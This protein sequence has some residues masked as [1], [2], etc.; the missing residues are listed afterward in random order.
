MPEDPID[1]IVPVPHTPLSEEA[2]ATLQQDLDAED[3]VGSSKTHSDNE[4]YLKLQEAHNKLHELHNWRVRHRAALEDLAALNLLNEKMTISLD[5]EENT[6]PEA[7]DTNFE[8]FKNRYGETDGK[9]CIEALVAGSDFDEQVRQELGRRGELDENDH[10][11]RVNYEDNDEP[12]IQRV[13]I[14][15]PALLWLLHKSLGDDSPMLEWRGQNRTTFYRPFTWFVYAREKMKEELKNLEAHWSS[16]S[17]C[18]TV[19]TKRE[20]MEETAARLQH[21]L[22]VD[23]VSESATVSMEPGPASGITNEGTITKPKSLARRIDTSLLQKALLENYH[24]LL[25]LRCYT[26]F[27]EKR[28][29]P[30]TRRYEDH[31]K[32]EAQTIRYQ[33]LWLLFPL[34]SLLLPGAICDQVVGFP[35]QKRCYWTQPEYLACRSRKA[36]DSYED[37]R[38]YFHVFEHNGEE[39][40]RTGR[41]VT[42]IFLKVLRKK[43]LGEN[44]KK[45]KDAIDSRHMGYRG[46][47]RPWPPPTTSGPKGP[48]G[49]DRPSTTQ[50]AESAVA[51]VR[52]QTYIE[53]DI[54]V[55]VKEAIRV[56]AEAIPFFT[57]NYAG[58]A[59]LFIRTLPQAKD[60]KNHTLTPDDLLLL[61]DRIYA[62]ALRERKFFK[63]DVRY[64]CQLQT[65]VDAFDSLKIDQ[66][67]IRIVQA[68]VASHF[69]R[70]GMEDRPE[71]MNM[72]DQDLIR[73]KGRGL[74]ILLHGAPGV[75]KTATAEAVALW[76]KRPLFVITC[77][78]LGFTPEGVES[79]LSEIFR[80]AHLWD[81]ILL[82]DEADVFLSQRETH[83]LQRNA[84]VSVFLRVLEYYNGILF[85]TT[86]RVGTLDEAFKSRVHLSLYY[87]ALGKEQTQDIIRMNL[88]RLRTIEAQR[89]KITEQMPL[90][91]EEK[92]ICD[93]SAKHF[94]RHAANDGAG[95]WN[96]RQIRNAVQIAASLAWYDRKTSKEPGAEKL[97]PI[98]D[99]RHFHTVEETMTLF[100][101]YMAKTKGGDGGFIAEQRGERYDRFQT[102]DARRREGTRPEAIE[103]NPFNPNGRPG[104]G[105]YHPYPDR[106]RTPQQVLSAAGPSHV[107]ATG[108]PY[109]GP[110]GQPYGQNLPQHHHQSQA[111]QGFGGQAQQCT[112]LTPSPSFNSVHPDQRPYMSPG[113]SGMQGYSQSQ[114]PQQQPPQATYGT[115]GAMYNPDRQQGVDYQHGGSAPRS[116]HQSNDSF[117]AQGS[118]MQYMSQGEANVAPGQSSFHQQGHWPGAQSAP[119]QGM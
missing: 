116:V 98:L 2:L 80:L 39:F 107:H 8:L 24:T 47:S 104:N 77:G 87:P 18:L 56:S 48:G 79:S 49:D 3:R 109:A 65:D 38:V 112:P 115:P 117:R 34:V 9:N 69:Q 43:S 113:G 101:G 60:M 16:A 50:Q 15:S 52:N 33:D 75:G 99:A 119:G 92:D 78:D 44:G 70:K 23:V 12:I 105:G 30:P 58:P 71:F 17:E 84:L 27:V 106:Q 64:L 46:W 51:I 89:A 118:D 6:I 25:E 93:F 13:R 67:H 111:Q 10:K 73:G 53:S 85:L 54:I 63:A 32:P 114:T 81:C 59:P 86:N 42:I 20:T 37:F 45:Y 41:Y 55:D 26:E 83:A 100:E 90:F 95:R 1:T 7:R 19:E 28:I 91:I 68:V 62:Y 4:R 29:L 36:R 57:A 14:Q 94:D 72:I 40:G 108:S 61:P 31:N 110:S 5:N 66:S 35:T 82:L 103:T 97:P 11:R 74:V 21:S 22:S 96:G 76:H 102:P 88:D